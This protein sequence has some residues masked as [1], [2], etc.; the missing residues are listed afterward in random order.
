MLD[1][2]L[3]QPTPPC[4]LSYA[5]GVTLPAC[6]RFHNFDLHSGKREICIYKDCIIIII[7]NGRAYNN[8][9]IFFHP[10][11]SSDPF[12]LCAWKYATHKPIQQGLTNNVNEAGREYL[13]QRMKSRNFETTRSAIMKENKTKYTLDPGIYFLIKTNEYKII[14]KSTKNSLIR[15]SPY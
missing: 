6:M 2:T 9:Q 1:L 11:V 13:Y 14:I 15:T 12:F 8:G 7:P 3:F 5:F 4:K 10:D